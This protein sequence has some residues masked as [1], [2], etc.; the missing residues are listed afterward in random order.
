MF[1]A[2]WFESSV[3]R[4][5]LSNA[6]RPISIYKAVQQDVYNRSVGR[7]RRLYS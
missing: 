7:R 3:K 4:P 5:G 6:S 1:K 2:D